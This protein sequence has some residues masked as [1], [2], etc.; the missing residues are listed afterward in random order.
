[1]RPSLSNSGKLLALL[2]ASSWPLIAEAQV[3]NYPQSVDGLSGRAGG[4]RGGNVRSSEGAEFLLIPV[5][6][7]SVAMGGAVAA[8][9]GF[10]EA[11]LWSPAGLAALSEPRLM[12]SHSESAFDTQSDVVGFLWPT[13][14]F[15]TLGV[16]YYLVDFGEL[17]NTDATGAVRGT[18]TFRNQEFLLSF[19]TRLIGSLEAGVSYKLIQLVFRCDGQCPEAR[20]FTRSTHA[21]DIGLL[22]DRPVGLPLTIGGTIRHLGFPLEGAREDDPLPTRMRLGIVY[23]ALRAFTGDSPFALA[24][25]VDVEDRLREPGDPDLMMGSEFGVAESF[26][27]RAGYAFQSTGAGGPALG[28]GLTHDWFYLDLSRGFDD[29]SVSDAESLQVSFGVIF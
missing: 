12:F 29:I 7:R 17:A 23:E 8:S 9:R 27:L 10:S 3:P 16:A 6:A 22:Y 2:V 20:S 19:A 18:I 13:N 21:M 4:G 15:G 5:G 24:I 26:F 14:S 28:L 25:A 1:M 11:V